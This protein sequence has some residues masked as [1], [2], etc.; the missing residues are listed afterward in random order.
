MKSDRY[1]EFEGALFEEHVR[2]MDVYDKPAVIVAKRMDPKEG[3]PA[4]MNL[5]VH[6]HDTVDYVTMH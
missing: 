6:Y 1:F 3:E 2:F 4:W 5:Q